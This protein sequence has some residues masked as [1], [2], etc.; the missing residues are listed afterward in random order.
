MLSANLEDYDY[1][2]LPCNTA[3]TANLTADDTLP[4]EDSSVAELRANVI[5][6]NVESYKKDEA[7]KAKIDALT[8]AIL[9]KSVA[10]YIKSTWNG[11][12]ATYQK[13]LL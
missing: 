5:A 11:V 4:V 10:S 1:A 6:A 13:S 3:L 12:I 8:E 7:Y 2:A 9:D